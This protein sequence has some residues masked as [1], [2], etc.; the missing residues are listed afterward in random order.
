MHAIHARNPPSHVREGVG[1]P[2]A[3][4]LLPSPRP[5]PP[6]RIHPLPADFDWQGTCAAVH[7]T[8]FVDTVVAGD[9]TGT[10]L[11]SYPLAED[12]NYQFWVFADAYKATI[13]KET[14]AEVEEDVFEAH[15]LG[16]VS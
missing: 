5:R 14:G 9:M 4:A 8:G 6:T 7:A 11:G 1:S 3:C 15:N 2:G 13:T 12:G 10:A 16:L